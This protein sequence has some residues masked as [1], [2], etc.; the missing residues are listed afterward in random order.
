MLLSIHRKYGYGRLKSYFGIGV[1]E[2]CEI[3]G[4]Y[5]LKTQ[6]IDKKEH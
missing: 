2:H 5:C 1:A 6:R 3:T 4:F